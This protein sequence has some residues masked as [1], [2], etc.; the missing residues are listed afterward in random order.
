MTLRAA[1]KIADRVERDLRDAF[2]ETDVICHQDP[3]G[4]SSGEGPPRF[5]EEALPDGGDQT[6]ASSPQTS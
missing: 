3:A 1:H 5:P 6:A 2:P 4:D